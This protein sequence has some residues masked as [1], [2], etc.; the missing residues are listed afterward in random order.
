[1]E[2]SKHEVSV[3]CIP[4]LANHV[5][6]VVLSCTL[7]DA[8]FYLSDNFTKF[9]DFCNFHN[10]SKFC[11]IQFCPALSS[12][13][14]WTHVMIL[15]FRYFC[16][17]SKFCKIQFPPALSSNLIWAYLMIIQNFMNFAVFVTVFKNWSVATLSLEYN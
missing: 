7:I 11:K 17:F 3:T 9:H 16:N 10:Y 8:H 14:I 1:M 12:S 5:K 15:K 2:I 13:P 6:F 4:H